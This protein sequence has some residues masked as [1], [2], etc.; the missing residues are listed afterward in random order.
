MKRQAKT[1]LPLLKRIIMTILAKVQKLEKPM[2]KYSSYTHHLRFSP[3]CHHNK[4]LLKDLDL[5]SR[6]KTELSKT[7]LQRVKTRVNTY[8]SCYI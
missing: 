8:Q 3:R 1:F 7:I 5:I 6:A 4:I 2:I